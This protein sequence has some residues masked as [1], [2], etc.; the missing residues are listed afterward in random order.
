M[1]A[2]FGEHENGRDDGGSEIAA[3]DFLA[4]F[5]EVDAVVRDFDLGSFG[6]KDEVGV[7]HDLNGTGVVAGDIGAG[8]L[9]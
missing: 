7:V 3:V 5:E 2:G 6:E 4:V 9:F 8:A 1:L